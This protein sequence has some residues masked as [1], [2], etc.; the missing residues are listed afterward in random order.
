ML[1]DVAF[2]M[3]FEVEANEAAEPFFIAI[4]LVGFDVLADDFVNFAALY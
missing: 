4:V 1:F 2:S 3:V